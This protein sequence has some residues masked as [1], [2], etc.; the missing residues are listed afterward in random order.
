MGLKSF[1]KKSKEGLV[2]RGVSF[3][4]GL[5]STTA[6]SA[7]IT[8]YNLIPGQ[9]TDILSSALYSTIAMTVVGNKNKKLEFL[10][11]MSPAILGSLDEYLHFFELMNYAIPSSKWTNVSDPYDILAYF[12]GSL[13]VY[14]G[15]SSLNMWRKNRKKKNGK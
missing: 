14:T 11:A 4:Y 12:T 5:A 8:S 6:I 15:A 3:S 7:V 2:S 10:A 13:I 1:L 9:K